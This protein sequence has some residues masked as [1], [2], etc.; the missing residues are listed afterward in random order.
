MRLVLLECVRGFGWCV[1]L[2]C[3]GKA[4][5]P[6]SARDGTASVHAISLGNHIT[7]MRFVNFE[8]ERAHITF[9]THHLRLLKKFLEV[10]VILLRSPIPEALRRPSH[11]Y[12]Y[13]EGTDAT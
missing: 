2:R 11:Q 4:S 6:P 3:V 9:E 8:W 1:A 5:A 7:P 13:L 10:S 12:K